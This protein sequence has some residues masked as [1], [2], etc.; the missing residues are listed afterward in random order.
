MKV[1]E[2]QVIAKRILQFYDKYGVKETV[3]HFAADGE[4]PNT[5]R[6]IIRRYLRTGTSEFRP[7]PGRSRTVATPKVTNAVKRKLMNKCQP[8]RSV[9]KDLCISQT[10]VHNIK[11]RLKIKTNKCSIAPKYTQNQLKRAKTNSRK[12]YRKALNKI[13]VIDDETYVTCDPRE[14]GGQRFYN[15][16]DKNKVPDNLRFKPNSKFP[17]RF[18]VWQA[19]DQ[20]GNVSEPYVKVGTLKAE[21]YK[22]EC[23]QKILLPFIHKHHS[24]NQVL[25]W[26]DMATIHYQN[27]VQNWLKAN[28]VQYVAK[29]ENPPN[30]PQARPIERFWHLCKLEYSKRSKVPKGI[31]GF[32]KIW[33]NISKTV[34]ERHA[35]ALMKNIRTTLR[36]IGSKGVYAPFKTK[37]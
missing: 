9:A 18:L 16:I 22:T 21:E 20:L 24:V 11:T 25:F 7:K 15:F 30:V 33:S 35:K 28:D 26:P 8:E 5:I 17:K 32:K 6:S 4:K 37:N 3:R 36:L 2:R 19:L 23:L 29:N 10:T 12:V 34:A 14:T 13:L 27:G 1:I 31:I